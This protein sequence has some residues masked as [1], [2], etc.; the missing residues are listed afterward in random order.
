[1]K[2]EAELTV[3]RATLGAMLILLGV[4]ALI[5]LPGWVF[6]LV[7]AVILLGSAL[8]QRQRGWEV[9]IWTWLFGVL[10]AIVAVLDLVGK[11]FAFLWSLWPL[12]LIALGVLLLINM[13]SEKPR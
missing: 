5:R 2:S 4:V 13:F 9:S 6:P 7:A 3:E 12:V 8:Y 11:V 1:M 10:F